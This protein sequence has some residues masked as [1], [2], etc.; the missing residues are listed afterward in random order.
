MAQIAILVPGDELY[1]Q[2]HDVLQELKRTDITVKKTDTDTAVTEARRAMQDGTEIIVTRGLQAILIK[3]YTDVAVVEIAL[4]KEGMI[5][6]IERAKSVVGGKKPHVAV[7][8]SR[9]MACDMSGVAK[10]CGVTLSEYY[11]QNAELMES[12]AMQAIEEK[13]AILIGGHRVCDVAEREGVPSLFV[14]NKRES[15]L[16]AIREAIQLSTVIEKEEWAQEKEEQDHTFINL[17][18]RSADMSLCVKQAKLLAETNVPMLIVDPGMKCARAFALAIHNCGPSGKGRLMTFDC[19][20]TGD[21]YNALFG[22]EGIIGQVHRGTLLLL[23]VEALAPDAQRKLSEMLAFCHVIAVS[24]RSDLKKRLVPELYYALSAFLI[25]IPPLN[26]RR[27][28]VACYAEEQF[29][30]ICVQMEKPCA[31]SREAMRAIQ[32]ADWPG[33]EIQLSAF[34]QRLIAEMKKRRVTERDIR[35]LYK[36]LYGKSEQ[37]RLYDGGDDVAQDIRDRILSVLEKN[38]GNREKSAKELGISKTTLWRR[39]KEYGIE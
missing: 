9:N 13:A 29:A 11:V 17:P 35:Q 21:N 2:A 8:I 38:L 6:V 1:Q 28:D 20:G 18:Y 25:H 32:E 22:K 4:T 26:E 10:K 15:M 14:I 37:G 19:G 34:L 36:T 5:E 39:L 7:I 30:D 16:R 12:A 24:A 33:G 31:L 27:E 23:E 3:Q